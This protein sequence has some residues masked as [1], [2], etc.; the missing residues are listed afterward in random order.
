MDQY[1]YIQEK[2]WTKIQH[3]F[4]VKI[5]NKQRRQRNFLNLIKNIFENLQL[6]SYLM[7]RRLTLTKIKDKTKMSS[8][9]TVLIFFLIFKKILRRAGFFFFHYTKTYKIGGDDIRMYHCEFRLLL[10][11]LLL[12][13]RM[14]SYLQ[15][16]PK[17]RG[18]LNHYVIYINVRFC[19]KLLLPLLEYPQ[20]LLSSW[21]DPHLPLAACLFGMPFTDFPLYLAE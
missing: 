8:L 17:C 3:P 1:Q 14:L 16:N 5:F 19:L 13:V 18:S 9:A 21:A 12:K 20:L 11:H 10:H 6:T 4:M 2:H 7:V 15:Q